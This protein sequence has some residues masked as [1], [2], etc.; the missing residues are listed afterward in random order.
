MPYDSVSLKPDG[1]MC[2]FKEQIIEDVDVVIQFEHSPDG[3]IAL[4]LF[5]DVLT[6]GNREL[7]FENGELTATGT[8]MTG[9]CKPTW[10][11]EI[12]GNDNA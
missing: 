2:E 4:R 7:L 5:G 8:H 3:L 9:G 1:K 10:M 12:E 6:C 11:T